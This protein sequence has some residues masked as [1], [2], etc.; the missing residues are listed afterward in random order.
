LNLE[1]VESTLEF[2]WSCPG[3]PLEIQ[4]NLQDF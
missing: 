4:W 2:G 1:F 3:I